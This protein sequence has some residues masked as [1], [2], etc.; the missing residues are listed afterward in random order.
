CTGA[1]SA[2]FRAAALPSVVYG[3]SKA[4]QFVFVKYGDTKAH[5]RPVNA[6][7]KGIIPKKGIPILH[8]HRRFLD[9][10]FDYIFDWNLCK[11]GVKPDPRGD[12]GEVPLSRV[13]TESHIT[14][15]HPIGCAQFHGCLFPFLGYHVDPV[16]ENLKVCGIHPFQTRSL[17][18][19][20]RLRLEPLN[21]FHIP[22][23][24]QTVHNEPPSMLEERLPL[25][26][27]KACGKVTIERKTPPGLDNIGGVR[28]FYQCRTHDTVAW[29]KSFKR[30]NRGFNEIAAVPGCLSRMLLRRFGWFGALYFGF[31]N[32]L[33]RRFHCRRE[34]KTLNIDAADRKGSLRRIYGRVLFRK[35]LADV[36]EIPRRLNNE[37]GRDN[38]C[39]V[40]LHP[41]AH[42]DFEPELN[43]LLSVAFQLKIAD[44]KPFEFIHHGIET[45]DVFGIRL[46][47]PLEDLHCLRSFP[48]L[49]DIDR[50]SPIGAEYWGKEW[51]QDPAHLQ[52]RSKTTDM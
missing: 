2:R 20:Q 12:H 32:R 49:L 47:G 43:V 38:L 5:I 29:L 42:V 14:P 18:R 8:A 13:D 45:V 9:P 48:D 28:G 23:I 7:I 52:V 31:L 35:F 34:V 46:C 51:Y 40:V 6:S 21:D 37:V 17:F 3:T 33:N 44:R 30:K 16:G 25:N 39:Q 11:N 50:R 10:V 41:V 1:Q 15:T 26:S 19:C 24:C 4:N 27:F 36:P 22:T